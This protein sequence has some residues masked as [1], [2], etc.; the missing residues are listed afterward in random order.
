MLRLVVIKP[1]NW[2]S[3]ELVGHPEHRAF[4]RLAFNLSNVKAYLIGEGGYYVHLKVRN[5]TI[6]D[7]PT[8]K[9]RMLDWLPIISLILLI[10]PNIIVVLGLANHIPALLSKLF[11]PHA[12]YYMFVIGEFE[13]HYSSSKLS[14]KIAN[15]IAIG[16]FSALFKVL[17]NRLVSDIYAISN[18]IKRCLVRINRRAGERAIVYYYDVP[19]ATPPADV[20]YEKAKSPVFKVLT[21]AGVEFRKGLHDV[22]GSAVIVNKILGED[23]NKIRFIIKG[24][25]RDW[26]YWHQLSK[27][28][29]RFNADNIEI[30]TTFLNYEDLVA[31]YR[32]SH[33]FLFPTYAD[34]L[35]LVALEA[36]SQRLP[37]IT[38]QTG[39]VVDMIFD[40]VN[41][42]LVRPGA[43]LDLAE[44]ILELMRNR[45][46]YTSLCTR[47]LETLSYYWQ[48]KLPF[49]NAT[50]NI[51]REMRN[52]VRYYYF[53]RS[54]DP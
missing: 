17:G 13:W 52:I 5:I 48:G 29:N 54:T 19:Y 11:L 7:L 10:R 28:I 1:S 32:D 4:L 21:I 42:Y 44:K 22:V 46:K 30:V 8:R 24:N 37:V 47:T 16:L 43:R 12:K 35:G 14:G 49:E 2:S 18:Y 31:L 23:R 53:S 51:F 25:I 9:L 27:L 33:I 34:A 15:L 50:E 45:E 40:G 36:L 3:K 20:C 41:G 6:V 38:Y 26:Q 39:G